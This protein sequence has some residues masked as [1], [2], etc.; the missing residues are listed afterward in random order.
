MCTYTN[1][2]ISDKEVLYE[3]YEEG[4]DKQYLTKGKE[5]SFSHVQMLLQ[6]RTV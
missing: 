2:T 1:G 6:T 4:I 3:N 5:I